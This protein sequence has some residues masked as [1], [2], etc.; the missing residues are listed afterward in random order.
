[1]G[2]GYGFRWTP[3]VSVGQKKA[4]AVKW[5][6]RVANK[7]KRAPAPVQIDGRAI[8]KTF[9]GKAW[10][11]NLEVYSDFSNRL[12]R[13][14]TYVRNGSVVDLVIK[15]GKVDAIVAG[16]DPYTVTIAISTLAAA[17]WRRIKKDCAAS[18]DS[19]LD[20]LAGRLS[21]GVMNRLTEKNGGCFPAP[22]EIKMSCSCPDYSYCCKHIAAVMY[23]IGSRLDSQPELLFVLRGVNHEE[24]VTQA[25]SRDNL[26]RELATD[27][28][29]ALAG[30]DLG[31]IFGIELDEHA[32]SNP[33]TSKRSKSNRSSRKP[34]LH[35]DAGTPSKRTPK[36]ASP[37]I[38]RKPATTPKSKR[39]KSATD[40]PNKPYFSDESG[41]ISRL[42]FHDCAFTPRTEEFPIQSA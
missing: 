8:A 12:P 40:P 23:G 5:A 42:T 6:V 14:A 30:E 32:A 19:L 37:K 1:M 34:R 3:Y 22:R 27:Q 10:C 25:V 20:L 2:Y 35:Q 17:T 24:L 28:T 15:P 13:G 21:D 26:D 41:E 39:V 29:M 4:K 7:Q 18:I 11:N 38:M 33:P 9:W 36:H 31:A 16:S